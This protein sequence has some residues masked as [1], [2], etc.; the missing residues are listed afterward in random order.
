LGFY[1]F[2]ECLRMYQASFLKKSTISN[3]RD[4]Y[5]VTLKLIFLKI[6]REENF[7]ENFKASRGLQKRDSFRIF[8]Q[9]V[10]V[11]KFSMLIVIF[12]SKKYIEKIL[13]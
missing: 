10:L 1:F 12:V 4:G 13:L 11:V 5:P 2:S 7:G 9:S 3:V 6:S 8:Q